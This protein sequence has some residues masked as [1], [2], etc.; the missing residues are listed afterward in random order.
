[1]T[2]FGLCVFSGGLERTNSDAAAEALRAAGYEVFRL[3]QGRSSG[4]I[5]PTL[6]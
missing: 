3:P 1:M 6:R 4:K 5:E 2:I